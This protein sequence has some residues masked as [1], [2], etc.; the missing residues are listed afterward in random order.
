VR[1][2]LAF[3]L[4]LG[5]LPTLA[6]AT[7]HELNVVPFGISAYRIDGV[8]NPTLTLIRGHTYIFHVDALGHPFYI[9]TNFSIG[10]GNAFN[11]GVTSNGN[12]NGD[13][14]FVVPQSAPNTLFYNCAVHSTMRGTLNITNRGVPG[15]MP[16]G[17][18]VLALLIAGLGVRRM[19][20]RT[21]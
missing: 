13:V 5:F 14:V 10:T 20:R 11:T 16:M 7:V 3:A 15:L 21:A 18:G 2:I 6:H 17:A 12:D 9:K 4:L 1:R 8:N 19:R